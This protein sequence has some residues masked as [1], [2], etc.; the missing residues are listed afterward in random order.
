MPRPAHGDLTQ[1]VNRAARAAE[2]EPLPAAAEQEPRAPR[3][4]P[5][6][7]H[8]KGIVVYVDRG[9]HRRLRQIGL[10]E[11]RSLQALMTEAIEMYLASPAREA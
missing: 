10:A 6:R 2:D 4:R 5:D 11:E 9:V 7:R 8:R 3:G 1:L